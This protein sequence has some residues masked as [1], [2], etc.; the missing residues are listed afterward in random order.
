M[1]DFT[2]TEVRRESPKVYNA[3]Q[4]DGAVTITHRDRPKMVLITE[5][6]LKQL[7]NEKTA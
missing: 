4:R 2:P 6:K 7:K 5:E 3:V 1:I